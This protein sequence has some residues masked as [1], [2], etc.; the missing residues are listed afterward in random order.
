MSAFPGSH[1]FRVIERS[2]SFEPATVHPHLEYSRKM[3]RLPAD[4]DLPMISS[5]KRIVDSQ[6]FPDYAIPEKRTD[7][8]KPKR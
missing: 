8:K 5:I 7:G 4:Y 1:R 6:S 3:V 2:S